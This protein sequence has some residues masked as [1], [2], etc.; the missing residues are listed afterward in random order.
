MF[1]CANCKRSSA[2]TLTTCPMCC[3]VVCTKCYLYDAGLSACLVCQQV[4]DPPSPPL[5]LDQML[6]DDEAV[7]DVIRAVNEE[8]LPNEPHE[9]LGLSNLGN[10]CYINVIVQI[11]LH[12]PSL[13]KA[14]TDVYDPR[15]KML[16]SMRSDYCRFAGITESEQCDSLLFL[17]WLLDKCADTEKSQWTQRWRSMIKCT[18]CGH[19]SKTEAVEDSVWILYPPPPSDGPVEL[20]TCVNSSEIIDDKLCEKCQV[21]TRHEKRSNIFSFPRH[22]FFNVQN[23]AGRKMLPPE[24]FELND[25]R[26][27]K[28]R[29]I[30][31]HQG[32]QRYGHYKCY[33]LD[34]GKKWRCYNDKL[35]TSV[36]G[37]LENILELQSSHVTIPLLWYRRSKDET[38]K[39][40]DTNDASE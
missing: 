26:T 11:M 40:D 18:E 21:K 27:Y 15:K 24:E 37:G 28:L 33:M 25:K 3:S 19:K 7:F 16:S 23:F 14:V 29:G 31:M 22:M 6:I 35:V 32:S 17:S 30:V 2:I 36:M 39:E 8:E 4:D 12:S 34:S 9:C 20:E 1:V 5:L 13:W 38:K 10:S